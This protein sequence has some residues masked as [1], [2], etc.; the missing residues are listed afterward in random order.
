MP[1]LNSVNQNYQDVAAWRR[2]LHERPETGFDLHETE[3]FIAARLEEFGC[4]EIVRGIGQTGIVAIIRGRLGDGPTIGLRSDMDALPV[5]E[6]NTGPYISKNPGRMHAC[7][8]D[9]HAA[10]L[11]G[12]GRYLAETRNFAGSVALVFQPAEEIGQGAKAMIA[13]GLLDR[14]GISRFYGM[15]NMPGIPTGQF[16]ICPGPIMG[17]VGKFTLK[18]KGRGGHAARPHTTIDPVVVCAQLV[19]ALQTLVARETDPITSVVVTVTRVMAGTAYNIIPETAEI[20]GTVRTLEM[21][22]AER[23]QRRISE[24]CDGIAMATGAEIGFEYVQ[25]INTTYND[26]D[27][28]AFVADVAREVAGSVDVAVKPVL[29]GEDFSAMIE[30]RP[31]ALIFIGNGDTAGLHHPA[32]DFDDEAIPAGVSYWARLV[33]R[34]LKA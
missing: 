2:S 25:T 15:H 26:A 13:D 12:A 5:T 3:A 1:I 24:I 14:F 29:A 34:A 27:E 4:D 10:M 31:G 32:Y 30:A 20:W 21:A 18:I 19:G 17:S 28:T 23:T 22:D 11:L 7:G 6:I 9:G 16:A 8:H 33:E